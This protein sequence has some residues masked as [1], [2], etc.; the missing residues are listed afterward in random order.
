MNKP[1]AFKG[2]GL[3]DKQ[4]GRTGMFVVH[5][6]LFSWITAHGF[7]L[8]CVQHGCFKFFAPYA[9][10]STVRVD[11]SSSSDKMTNKI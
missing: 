11:F 3:V 2:P 9:S 8:F 5:A 4:A 6:P 7:P 10:A 1:C